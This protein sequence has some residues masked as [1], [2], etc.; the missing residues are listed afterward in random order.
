MNLTLLDELEGEVFKDVFNG[1]ADELSA[2]EPKRTSIKF[3]FLSL[4]ILLLL[5]LFDAIGIIE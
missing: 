2:F 5:L 3:C 1:L 4:S